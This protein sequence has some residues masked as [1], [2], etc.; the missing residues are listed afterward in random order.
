VF[1]RSDGSLEGV[2]AVIDKD[3]ASACLAREINAHILMI[4]TNVPGVYMDFGTPNQHLL[5]RVR[6][7]ELRTLLQKGAFPSGS[8][9]PKIEAVVQFIEHG[10]ERAVIAQLED[11]ETALKG[12][13]GTSIVP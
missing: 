4:L 1:E 6:A 5:K 13:S 10:G 2:E 3:L 11:A 12:K 9:G 7:K 8:I